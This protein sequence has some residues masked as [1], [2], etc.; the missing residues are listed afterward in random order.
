MHAI[1]MAP[2]DLLWNGGIGTYVKASTETHADVGDKANDAI[3]VNGAE[4]RVPGGRRGRQPRLHPAAA[5]SSARARGGR[6]NTDAIDNSA[7][8]DTSDHEVNIKILLDR[9]VR[10]GR[11]DRERAQRRC[12]R[13]MTD[14]VAHA[15]AAR[16]LRAERPARQRPRAGARPMVTVHQRLHAATSR[17]PGRLDRALEFL[18]VRRARSTHR[19]AAGEG[20]T[21]AG[22]G[23]CGRL[24][25]DH[26]DRADLLESDRARTSRGS[27]DVA[28]AVL[29]AAD[30]ASGSPTTWTAIRCAARSSRPAWSTTWSTAAA[31][32]S[33]YR[34]MEETGADPARSRAPTRSAARC[35]AC[36]QLWAAI[37][38]LDNE[39]PTDAQHARLPRG[40]PPHRPRDALA[41]RRAVP[42][43]RRRRRDR[44]IPPHGSGVVAEDPG[45]AAR[46]TS[47][48]TCTPRSTVSSAWAC[49]ATWRCGSA[50]C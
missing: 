46:R 9:S 18:P 24:R 33:C 29:P 1:L 2:V 36:E 37:E 12:S 20:L 35:S 47:A 50:S 17:T 11:P 15:R 44:A 32:R 13:Q 3:R 40:P 5:A 28:D 6:I 19:E 7:G 26:A 16:Q 34:A 10:A 14:E 22:A 43:H 25:Q 31:S 21:L 42:D 8:V 49:P 23:R 30:R 45:A 27:S 4:L 38:D 48:R 41:G 39:V